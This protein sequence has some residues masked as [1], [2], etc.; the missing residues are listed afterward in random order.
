LNLIEQ[1][2]AGHYP[3]GTARRAERRQILTRHLRAASMHC[4][5][6]G[7]EKDAWMLYRTS[8]LWNARQLRLKYLLGFPLT[9]ARSGASY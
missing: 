6:A 8:F 7:Q 4:L 3:G 9:A 1:E 5:A 2:R